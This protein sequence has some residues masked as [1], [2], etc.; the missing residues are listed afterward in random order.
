MF[1]MNVLEMHLMRA[2]MQ[3]NDLFCL[4]QILNKE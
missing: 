3:G 4:K 2:D 1:T